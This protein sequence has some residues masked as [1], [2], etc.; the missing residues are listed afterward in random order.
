M[1]IYEEK[2]LREFEFWAGASDFAKR[3]TSD[4]WDVLEDYFNECYPNGIDAT[5]L[6]DCFWFDNEFLLELIGVS[7]DDFWNR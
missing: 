2:D 1:K 3:L 6:N 5:T 7:E 4:E